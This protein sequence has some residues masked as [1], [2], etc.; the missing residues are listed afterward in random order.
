MKLFTLASSCLQTAAALLFPPRCPVCGE[1]TG[2][3]IEGDLCKYCLTAF[4]DKYVTICPECGRKADSC[5][6]APDAV[7]GESTLSPFTTVLPLIFDGFY[8]GYEEDSPVSTL[9]YRMKRDD[10][11]YAAVVFSRII[12]G[13][14]SRELVLR[15][16]DPAEFTV[17]Y[18]PRSQSALRKY[19]FDHME[20]AAKRVSK[21]LGCSYESLLCRKGG[22]DQKKLS[23]EERITNAESSISISP[24]KKDHVV[25]KKLILL[26]DIITTGA[27]M[28]SAV[29]RLSFAGADTIIPVCAMISKTAKRS[30][31]ISE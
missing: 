17:T 4:A 15:K 2:S 28:R 31:E 26:D 30:P 3:L 23:T 21:M 12:A 1:V 5:R 9:V 7:G 13:A 19:G 6:C 22:T 24:K 27:T 8:T 29:S 10:R 20:M 25:G 14:V 18:I 16:L 11:S